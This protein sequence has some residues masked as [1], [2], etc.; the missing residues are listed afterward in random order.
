[1]KDR[2]IKQ[3]QPRA[4]LGRNSLIEKNMSNGQIWY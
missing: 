2:K 4:V 3:I 1:M